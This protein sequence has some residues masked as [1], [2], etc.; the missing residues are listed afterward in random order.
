LKSLIKLLV[1]GLFALLRRVPFA[2]T[3]VLQIVLVLARPGV[4]STRSHRYLHPLNCSPTANAGR[5]ST[6][7]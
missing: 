6:L 2:V 3:V 5:A 1:E 7:L 4:A